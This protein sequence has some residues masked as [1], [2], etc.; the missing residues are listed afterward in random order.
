[1]STITR[2]ALR[3]HVDPVTDCHLFDGAKTNGYGVVGTAGKGTFR[4]HRLAY[5]EANGPIPDGLQLDHLCRNRACI[6]PAHLEPVTNA[7]NSR[8]GD[9]AK[10]DWSRV[11]EIRARYAAGGTSHRKLASEFG[12]SNCAIC[13]ILNGDRWQEGA[14]PK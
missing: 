3:Y 9:R 5:V 6:N 10:L 12:V 7:E 2:P 11:R 14:C 1:M 4:A 8:R 13:K